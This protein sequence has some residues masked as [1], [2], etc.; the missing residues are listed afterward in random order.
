MVGIDTPFCFPFADTAPEM[1]GIL[2]GDISKIVETSIHT[3]YAIA[4]ANCRPAVN[5]SPFKN[6]VVPGRTTKSPS[7]G[8]GRTA[9]TA[10]SVVIRVRIKRVKLLIL[11][12]T[13]A[14]ALILPT[15]VQQLSQLI[16]APFT[17]EEYSPMR[18]LREE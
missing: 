5:A 8:P 2:L 16:K 13:E 18:A 1:V 17:V 10:E 3:L 15:N 9:S 14:V 4:F 11:P 7:E 12:R 6:A